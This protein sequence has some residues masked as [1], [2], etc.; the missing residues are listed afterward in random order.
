MKLKAEIA[1]DPSDIRYENLKHPSWKSYI[2][3]I[4]MG[5][6]F[7]IVLGVGTLA[8]FS[9]AVIFSMHPN[10]FS[11]L[12]YGV[13]ALLVKKVMVKLIKGTCSCLTNSSAIVH[14][15]G[16]LKTYSSEKLAIFVQVYIGLIGLTTLQYV[17]I[18][19]GGVTTTVAFESKIVRNSDEF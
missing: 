7:V 17:A 13:I 18:E 12:V 9:S 4:L 5:F 2:S 8:L 16:F 11:S 14:K 10:P 19:K 15:L 1:P 3:L 6:L